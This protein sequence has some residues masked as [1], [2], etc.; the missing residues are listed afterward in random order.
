MSARP[1]VALKKKGELAD[2]AAPGAKRRPTAS[3]PLRKSEDV[4][5]DELASGAPPGDVAGSGVSA[6]PGNLHWVKDKAPL[7][8][9]ARDAGP[10]PGDEHGPV[11]LPYQ[12]DL[13]HATSA[14]RVTVVEKSRRIGATWGVAADAALAA[15]AQRRAGGMDVFYIG[16]NRDMTREFIDTC[17]MWARAFSFAASQVEEFLFREQGEDGADREIQAFRIR[18]ASGFEI[19]ALSSRPRSLR[20]RQ[21]YVIIDEAAFHDELE[22]VMKA[23]LALL[24]WG[25][26]VL[27]ISTHDGSDNPFAQLVDDC[28]TGRA[29]Y[30]LLRVAFADALEQGLYQRVC[31]VTGAAW[32][33]EAEAAWS[34]EIRRFYR[35]AAGEELD[36]IPRNSGGRY[37]SRTMLEARAVDGPRVVRLAL[38]DGFVDLPE[39]ERWRRIA[40]FCSEEL[41]PL[42]PASAAASVVGEDFGR[43]GDLTVMWPLL[44]DNDL[45]RRTA[46]VLELRNVPFTSQSQILF[47]ICDTL[48]GFRGA[49]L[50]ARG[51]GQFLAEAARQRYGP[52]RIAEVMLSV[53][54]YREHMPRLKATLEDSEVDLPRDADIIDDLRSLE[55]VDGVARAPERS[56]QGSTGQRHADAAVALALAL[57]AASTL[58]D[59][60][61]IEVAAAGSYVSSIEAFAGNLGRRNLTGWTL[62]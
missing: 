2:G 11:L 37:L 31:K 43:S 49:A 16:F 41:A 59:G 54:W 8:A 3:T 56:R 44:V 60:G 35:D 36:C 7:A 17:G 34:E 46:F 22:E 42:M 29:P 14:N 28:R 38:E 25:G 61:P 55:V 45:R 32:S 57:F 47:W 58:D 62:P 15:G 30:K 27:V 24:L 40:D 6:S 53:P 51:N 33:P 13:L 21:G 50:D 12:Q 5:R 23:A 19:V 52:E 20:G 26:K 39:E 18:F 9:L 4:S 48:P 1:A 10:E